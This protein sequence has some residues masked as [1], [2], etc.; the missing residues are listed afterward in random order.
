MHARLFMCVCGYR[1]LA[2]EVVKRA[3]GVAKL[4]PVSSL[5]RFGAAKFVGTRRMFYDSAERQLHH[6]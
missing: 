4:T 5:P 6:F 1:A 2:D 3:N